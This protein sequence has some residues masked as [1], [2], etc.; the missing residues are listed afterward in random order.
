MASILRQLLHSVAPRTPHDI[1]PGPFDPKILGS[2][3]FVATVRS[4]L[5]LLQA[6]CPDYH[7]VVVNHVAVIE[8]AHEG[9]GRHH[10]EPP[11][12]ELE[13]DIG[14][15]RDLPPRSRIIWYAGAIVHEAWHSKLYREHRLENRGA[16]WPTDEGSAR[17][18][19]GVCLQVQHNALAR[20]GAPQWML[21]Y[22]SSEMGLG[23]EGAADRGS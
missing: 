1:E 23:P 22:V 11:R 20:M 14:H 13:S 9:A 17:E 6:D 8:S 3:D 5:D 2:D 16:P 4:A 12:I 15:G 18:R 21:D 10:E 19:E 7:E